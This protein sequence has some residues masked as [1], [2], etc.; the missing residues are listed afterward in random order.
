M[1]KRMNGANTTAQT[2]REHDCQSKFFLELNF[3]QF[4]VSGENVQALVWIYVRELPK[5][6]FR[7]YRSS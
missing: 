2:E 3:S 1:I 4:F 6:L 5:H 7:S